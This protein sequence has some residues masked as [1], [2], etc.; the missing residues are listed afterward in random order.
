MRTVVVE[1]LRGA[2][3]GFVYS[4]VLSIVGLV[5][6]VAFYIVFGSIILFTDIVHWLIDTMVEIFGLVAI[7][8]AIR[9]GRRFPWGLLGIESAT[10]L[11]SLAIALGIYLVSV[12]NYI[13]GEYSAGSVTTLNI[14]PAIATAIGGL[15]TFSTMIIQ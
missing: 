13:L 14:Y 7:Y 6:Q 12:A 3:R 15:L 2:Y 11:L 4:A 1:K 8:Y 5:L 9:I 10:I